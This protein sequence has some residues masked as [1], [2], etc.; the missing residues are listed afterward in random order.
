MTEFCQ[1]LQRSITEHKYAA[2]RQ[3][4]NSGEQ[5]LVEFANLD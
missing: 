5:K 3:Q 4:F 1:I 2:R